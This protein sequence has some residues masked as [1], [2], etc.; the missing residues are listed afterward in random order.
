MSI[1]GGE[2]TGLEQKSSASLNDQDR[3]GQSPLLPFAHRAIMG[4][5]ADLPQRSSSPLKRRASDLDGDRQNKE[6]IASQKEDVEMVTA[7]QSDQ[8]EDAVVSLSPVRTT[9]APS[10]DMLNDAQD[11]GVP[12]STGLTQDTSGVHLKNGR[13]AS[14]YVQSL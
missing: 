6:V 7:P 3:R 1:E 13:P 9:R 12:D 8:S 2:P 5:A 11:E 14:F 4:G 10:V